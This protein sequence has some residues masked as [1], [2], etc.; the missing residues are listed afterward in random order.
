MQSI[1]EK[2]D[3]SELSYMK[4]QLDRTTLSEGDE[5]EFFPFLGRKRRLTLNRTVLDFHTDNIRSS[6]RSLA[7][8]N[9][10]RVNK[11]KLHF[12]LMQVESFDQRKIASKRY[13]LFSLCKIPFKI[14]G[15]F[16]FKAYVEK[17]DKI[18]MGYSS[19]FICVEKEKF[20]HSALSNS[21]E[22]L[23][24]TNLPILLEGET[25]TG[26][27]SLAKKIHKKANSTRHFVHI[28]ISSYSP[29]LIESELFGHVKGAFTGA[30][31]TKKGAFLEAQDGT[32]FIDEIDSLPFDLQTKLLIFLDEKKIRPVGGYRDIKVN[33]RLIFAS[34]QKLESLLHK[35]IMRKDFYFRLNSGLKIR[36]PSLREDEK[37]VEIV[38]EQFAYENKIFIDPKLVEFYKTLPWPGNIRQLKSLLN[39]KMLLTNNSRLVFD[40]CDEKLMQE[41]T[42]LI[43]LNESFEKEVSMS[44]LKLQYVKK[45]LLKYNNNK[46]AVSKVL[47]ITPRSIN[48]ICKLEIKRQ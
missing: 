29:N 11:E 12:R 38:C 17:G 21:E 40:T 9:L 10:G 36:L 24:H 44:E 5:I 13:I 32:L 2:Y 15:Q 45:L 25:G 14:N 6:E 42:N 37:L 23:I 41:S 43:D 18:E 34:G 26:K 27:T 22:R 1:Q 7:S 39:K 19:L 28:N 35:S 33:C 3:F 4:E 47:G 20:K 30:V 8:Y 16:S 48:N 46:T 31:S